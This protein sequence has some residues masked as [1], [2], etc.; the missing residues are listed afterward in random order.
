M[1]LSLKTKI[2]AVASDVDGEGKYFPD[3]SQN[4]ISNDIMYEETPGLSEV[5]ERD[6]WNS[7]DEKYKHMLRAK[8]SN[9]RP[10]GIEKEFWKTLE[11]SEKT[12]IIYSLNKNEATK[13]VVKLERPEEIDPEIWEDIHMET[14]KKIVSQLYTIRPHGFDP[15]LWENLNEKNRQAI[16]Y[17][18][19]LSNERKDLEKAWLPVWFIEE[20]KPKGNR[21][22]RSYFLWWMQ[23]I[24]YKSRV[25]NFFVVGNNYIIE[26]PDGG[27]SAMVSIC[28]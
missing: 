9:L 1:I 14:R 15:E 18:Q 6:L 3:Q 4:N 10:N 23:R 28:M 25:V 11:D 27:M 12:D 8:L 22:K 20:V 24:T 16:A 13:V 21:S 7:L 5:I 2:V 26:E 17:D 19:K